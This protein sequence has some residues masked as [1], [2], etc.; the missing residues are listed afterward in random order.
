MGANTMPSIEIVPR[1]GLARIGE[2][3]ERVGYGAGVSADDLTLAARV[4]GR[5]AGAVRLSEEA[6]VIVLRGMQV[7]PAYQRQGIGRALLAYCLPWLDR[8]E[9]YCLPYEHLLGF[10]GMAGF[11][12]AASD[13]LPAFLA[14]RLGGYL[15][16]GQRVRAMRRLNRSCRTGRWRR[17]WPR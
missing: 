5:L 2:F 11:K 7:D 6:G 10:Y 1:A 14:S 12:P 3:Y 16:A 13:T 9:A 15:A 17:G 4:D 8:H